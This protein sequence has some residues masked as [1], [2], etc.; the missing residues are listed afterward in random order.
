LYG[1]A[2]ASPKDR[3]SPEFM[4]RSAE[5]SLKAKFVEFLFQKLFGK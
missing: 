3:E 2:L 4:A 1:I 5:N